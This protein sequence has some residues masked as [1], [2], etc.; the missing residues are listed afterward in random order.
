MR[1]AIVLMTVGSTVTVLSDGL[2]A[3]EGEPPEP[4]PKAV[5][6]DWADQD[7]L[8]ERGKLRPPAVRECIAELGRAGVELDREYAVLRTAPRVDLKRWLRL[9]HAACRIR[10]ERRLGP[11][12]DRI[13]RIVFTKHYDLGG[14]HYA[15]TEGQS[16]A[17]AERHFKAGSALCVLDL[18]GAF[19]KVRT[20]IEDRGGVIRDPDVSFDGR[21]VLFAWKKSDRQDDYHLYELNVGDVSAEPADGGAKARQITGGLGFADYE[22]AYLPNGRIVFNSTRC[23]QTVD[24]WW[25]EVSNLYMCDAGGRFLRRLSF[26]QVHTNYP[27][28]TPDGRVIYTRW[29]Y[30]DR[31]QIYPQG[32]FQMNADGTGQTELYGNNSYFPTALLHAR[33]IPGSGRYVAVFSG[34][35]TRQQGWLGVVDPSMGRQEDSG[36]QLIA[37]VRP[38]RAVRVDR[39]G[40]SGDQFQYP[41][42]LSEEAFLVTMR[43]AN[44][45]RRG[46]LRPMRTFAVYFLL[47][48]GRRELLVSDAKISCSQPVPLAPRPLPHR[49]PN[50]VDYRKDFGTVYMQDVYAGGGLTGVRRGSIKKLRVVTMAFRAAGVDSNRNRGPAGAALV[51]T[52]ISIQGAWDVKI[53]LGTATVH[54]DGSV[55]FV[56]PARRPIYFQALDAN[57]HAA[58]TMR[59]WVTLQPGEYVSCVGCH[60]DKNTAP[61][62]RPVTAALG[63]PPEEL[64]SFQGRPRGFSFHR[65]IQPILDKHCVRCHRGEPRGTSPTRHRPIAAP[66]PATTKPGQRIAFSLKGNPGQFSDAYRALAD[67]RVCNWISPQSAPPM[68]PPYHAGAAKSKLIHMLTGGHNKVKLSAAEMER[69]ACW[70]DLLVP[71]FGDYTERYMDARGKAKYLRYLAKRKKWQAE[72]QRNI[73]AYLRDGS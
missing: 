72:E 55:C 20:L 23:V 50:V 13:R 70:I 2:R 61:P 53:V 73:A 19:G 52:P 39:Y 38:T 62:N 8:Y 60:E 4:V 46:P 54:G 56:V 59:S 30:N 33:A 63:S 31:G 18:E 43:P 3:A 32:L 27:T 22:G 17:Q 15:Y 9:Y 24:C 11:Y 10:R 71:C 51:S 16:D 6:A 25:T 58:Q 66:P 42:P 69:I 7:E 65:E 40:Q 49:R 64:T 41:Y 44:A 34:H 28:V 67:R 26:D 45:G 47:A 1:L 57:G 14:S 35:H 68:L 21:R 5:A 36:A 48:D 29:D 37:P 12:R